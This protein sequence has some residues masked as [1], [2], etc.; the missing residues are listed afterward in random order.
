ML[1]GAE[2][3]HGA[4]ADAWFTH[5]A[6]EVPGAD[7]HYEWSDPVTGEEYDTLYK[8]GSNA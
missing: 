3:R 6:S 7:T 1:A 5:L 2:R 8:N 4:R